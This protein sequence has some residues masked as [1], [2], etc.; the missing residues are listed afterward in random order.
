MRKPTVLLVVLVE[1]VLGAQVQAAEIQVAWLRQNRCPLNAKLQAVF[2]RPAGAT[3]RERFT[4]L[5]MTKT[6]HL[7]VQCVISPE[8]PRL[9]CEAPSSSGMLPAN[10]SFAEPVNVGSVTALTKLGYAASA[11]GLPFAYR[12]DLNGKPDFNAIADFMLR[13]L[14]SGYGAD[15]DTEFSIEAPFRGA[16]VTACLR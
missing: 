2:E 5:R 11:Q 15:E 14:F 8:P 10:G 16:L 13:T 9:L 6:P 4:V 7:Y 12:R 3:E 1:L